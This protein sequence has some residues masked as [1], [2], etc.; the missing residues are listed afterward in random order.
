MWWK[1][2]ET[3]KIIRKM[4][5]KVPPSIPPSAGGKLTF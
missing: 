5:S 3:G 1:K 4:D 2:E